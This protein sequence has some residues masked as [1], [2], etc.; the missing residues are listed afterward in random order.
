MSSNYVLLA[1][2]ETKALTNYIT[3]SNIPQTGYTDLKIV[4]AGRDSGDDLVRFS[5]AFNSYSKQTFT[6]KVLYGPGTG[7]AGSSS[8]GTNTSIGHGTVRS[9]ATANTY[10]NCEIYIPNYSTNMAKMFSVD[11]AEENNATDA[12][13]GIGAGYTSTTDPIKS[14]SIFN[15]APYFAV[16]STFELYAMASAAVISTNAP[17][18]IGGDIITNDGE[19]WYHAFLSTGEFKPKTVLS[20]DILV[21]AGGGAGGAGHAGGA[22]GG[23]AGGLLGFTSQPLTSSSYTVTV[24]AGG[25]AQSSVNGAYVRI[26][27][28][29]SNSQ[30]GSLTAA[31]GGGGGAATMTDGANIQGN[32]GGSGGGTA[33]WNASTLVAGGQGTN[34][35]GYSAGQV[36]G[37]GYTRGA[38]GG[39]GAGGSSGAIGA[40]NSYDSTAGGIGSNSYSSWSYITN[41][42]VAGYYAGGGG[43]AN[44]GSA[45]AGGAGGGGAGYG[46][47]SSGTATSGTAYTGS[48]GG[49]ASADSSGILT[50]TS[51]AGGSGIVIVRYAMA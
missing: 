2:L 23:G 12:I 26:G 36:Q 39:G 28:N 22:G 48:G 42:G 25:A 14:I 51:G 19:Y 32:T 15:D 35:Q 20:C 27:N 6:R 8:F 50:F 24:G 47:S 43:G 10:G 49:G 33:F 11:G 18:A 30:F 45:K 5:M 9:G 37:P 34:G 41:T 29:G 16:G 3:F 46:T 1:R 40:A 21:I 4:M 44:A 31:I 17:K 13:M 38:S 7:S